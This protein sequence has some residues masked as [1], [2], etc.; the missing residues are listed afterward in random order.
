[1]I[2]LDNAATSF[3]KPEVVYTAMDR[4]LRQCGANPGRGGYRLALAAEQEIEETRRLLARMFGIRQPHR[5]V[6]TFNATHAL[7]IALKGLL[8]P[9]DHVITS[10]MEHNSVNRPLRALEARGVSV[11]RILCSPR[12]ELDVDDV[13]R[14][15]TSRT[16]LIAITH[17]SN[18]TGTLLPVAELGSLARDHDLLLLV[19]AAQT[20]GVYPIDVEELQIDLLAFPGH[21]GLL[22]PPG[23]GGLYIG[24]RAH[25]EP[26]MEGGTG[27]HSDSDRQPPEL[28]RRHES[29]TLNF[30][31]LAG[32]GAAVRFIGESGLDCIRKHHVA[33]TTRL[34]EGLR[35]IPGV[36]VYGPS[37][38]EQGV[39]V[40]SFT[41][42]AWEPLDLAAVL[43][44]SFDIACRAGLHCAPH[45]HRT[46]G[47]YPQGTVRFSPGF[48][49]TLQEMDTVVECLARVLGRG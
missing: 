35:E 32:L 25:P 17:A 18:V 21:K 4:F 13:R 30:A 15:I 40:L 42:S 31:G 3:P 2:Y 7:N 6:F 33:L 8:R 26:L 19:D 39:G 24:P 28:P 36:R 23:T 27:S 10:S 38:P 9:R 12:G 43:D 34:A 45:A 46:L 22:G 49:N 16:R 44:E 11:T 47:T 1:M 37:E 5:L 20:A 29:G 41:V 14:A 48:F